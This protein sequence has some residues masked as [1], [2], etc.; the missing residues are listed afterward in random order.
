M[1]N[2]IKLD[3]LSMKC[4]HKRFVIIPI[5]ILAYGLLHEAVIILFMVFL[6]HSFSV[7]PFAVEEKGKLD[8]LYLTLPV[9]RKNIVNARFSLALMMQFAGLILGSA[10]TLIYSALFYGK[11]VLYVF[12]HNFKPDFASMFLI[13]S[14]SLCFYAV[15]NLSTFPMLFKIGYAK[16]KMIGFIIP[17]VAA[18]A[19]GGVTVTLWNVSAGFK[20][21]ASAVIEWSFANTVLAAAVILFAAV[22]LFAVSYVLSQR[23]YAK[24]EL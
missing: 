2:M 10:V 23:A 1:L 22:L 7:N 4:Y 6:V 3:W 9:T 13:I 5:T 15:M 20:Q 19:M 17:L 8:N 16:G 11:T 21:T 18:S 24:R 12:L 14:G